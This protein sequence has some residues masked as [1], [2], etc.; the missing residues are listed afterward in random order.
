M[1]HI[2][3]TILPTRNCIRPTLFVTLFYLALSAFVIWFMPAISIA[4]SPDEDKEADAPWEISADTIAYLEENV[5]IAEGNVIISKGDQKITADRV[6]FDDNTKK[7]WGEGNVM[8]VDGSD[9]LTGERMEINLKTGTG[10]VHDGHLFIYESNFHIRGNWV[11]KVGP[12]TFHARRAQITACDRE[13][14]DWR[15]TGTNIKTTLE[16][17]AS[18]W[19]GVLWLW[20]IPVLYTPY[21][22]V[23]V[24]TDRQTGFLLP[25]F[26][27]SD[28]LGFEYQQPF[29]WA[30]NDS[31]DATFYYHYLTERGNKLG[32]ELRFVFTPAAYGAVM[33]DFLSDRCVEDGS[34]EATNDCGY[35]FDNYK[36][37]NQD[38]YWFRMKHDQGELPLGFS[39]KLDLDY[40]SDQDYLFDFKSGVNGFEAT[41]EFFEEFFGRDIDDFN[42]TTRVNKFNLNR[43][44]LHYNLDAGVIWTDDVIARLY[45]EKDLT[46]QQL[47]SITLDGLKQQVFQTPLYYS[48]ESGYERFWRQDGDESRNIT[49]LQRG[50]IYPRLFWPMRARY[51][52]TLEPSVGARYTYWN[53]DDYEPGFEEEESQFDRT[54]Y[55]AS[56][57]WASE[58]YRV[59]DIWGETVERIKHSIRPRI[60]YDYIPEE[61]QDELPYF[62][63]IDRINP[64]DEVTYSLVSLFTS[65]LIRGRDDQRLSA[66]D[67]TRKDQDDTLSQGQT[68][69]AD[70][71]MGAVGTSPAEGDKQYDYHEFL[72]LELSQTY[73]FFEA[74]D[75][76]IE[77]PEPLSPVYGE[78][79]FNPA[80]YLGL[81]A[82][83][84]WD[85]DEGQDIDRSLAV[86]LQNRRR[87]Y[88]TFRHRVRRENEATEFEEGRETIETFLRLQITRGLSGHATYQYDFIEDEQTL[89]GFGLLYESQCWS[90]GVNYREE[91]ED[92]RYTFMIGLLG[93]GR[94][95]Q[96]L[97]V[98]SGS[99]E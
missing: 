50:D 42:D 30:I 25:H 64:R 35:T 82:D 36:R 65:K 51:F 81:I 48:L 58:V 62:S 74:S 23:P 72:R 83:M 10:T 80:Y 77:D 97:G 45:G 71:A 49:A 22:V 31:T 75:D 28:R 52:F 76:E 17:Y 85:T 16:G 32:A 99:G 78:I 86:A 90:V 46:V 66:I 39:A 4:Q 47:P 19:N 88:L 95:Q 9:V 60:I 87:D 7:A 67:V 20:K 53:V 63:T 34:P 84:D 26:G 40:V 13:D 27:L 89:L 69:D 43:R 37:T 6:R 54:I 18:G 73:D 2:V 14:P 3:G 79:R 96:Q 8:V 70:T 21:L 15:F 11:E 98:S 1:Q 68:I 55:D 12:Q 94:Y 29:F 61:E 93:I 59:Y 41:D 38:R 56:V 44:W 92:Q 33:Y 57:T 24:K 91:F 5:V